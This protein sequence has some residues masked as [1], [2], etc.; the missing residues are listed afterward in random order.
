MV[1]FQFFKML[2]IRHLVLRLLQTTYE[3]SWNRQNYTADSNQLYEY[4][5]I[6][7]V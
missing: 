7:V 2:A 3:S 4:G 6:C 1:V 5:V